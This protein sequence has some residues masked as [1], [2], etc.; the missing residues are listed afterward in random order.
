MSNK[1]SE[2]VEK[3]LL[4]YVYQDTFDETT[5]L[6]RMSAWAIA[7]K[8]KRMEEALEYGV[9]HK[10]SELKFCGEKTWLENWEHVANKALSFD[11]LS[12]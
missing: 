4:G 12:E 7:Q 8:Y 3:E 9:K 10:E 11:P 6:Q 1:T 2:A 5:L